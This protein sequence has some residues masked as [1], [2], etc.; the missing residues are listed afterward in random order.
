MGEGASS[1]SHI[2]LRKGQGQTLS[3]R[4]LAITAPGVALHIQRHD[5]CSFEKSST[6]VYGTFGNISITNDANV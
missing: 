6:Y 3:Q 5:K 4:S 1:W 2:K